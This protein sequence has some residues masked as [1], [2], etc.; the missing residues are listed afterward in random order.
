VIQVA[1]DLSVVV[2]A[3]VSLRK[4]APFL[5]LALQAAVQSDSAGATCPRAKSWIYV[6]ADCFEG[7]FVGL[8][9]VTFV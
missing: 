5:A 3:F 1:I 8:I 7:L 6:L 4:A 9:D 2:S